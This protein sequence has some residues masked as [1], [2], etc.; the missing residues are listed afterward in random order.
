MEAEIR[1][2]QCTGGRDQ[3]GAGNALEAEIRCR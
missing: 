2:G 3:V 1:C